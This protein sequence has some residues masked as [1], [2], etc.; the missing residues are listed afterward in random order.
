MVTVDFDNCLVIGSSQSERICANTDLVDLGN[1]RSDGWTGGG[2]GLVTLCGAYGLI[3][4]DTT[5][6]LC[7]YVLKVFLLCFRWDGIP[8]NK[9]DTYD[10]S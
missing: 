4:S 1:V 5:Y 8:S 7:V 10:N 9:T 3:V 2:C 6:N